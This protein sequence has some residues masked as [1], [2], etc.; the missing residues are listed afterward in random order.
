MFLQNNNEA[1]RLY[2]LIN[3]KSELEYTEL[4]AYSVSGV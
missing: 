1:Y 2:Y 3:Q 4:S